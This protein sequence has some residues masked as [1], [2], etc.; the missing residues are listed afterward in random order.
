[1][2]V[3]FFVILKEY[4]CQIFSLDHVPQSEQLIRTYSKS[5]AETVMMY[6]RP[7]YVPDH[8]YYST[9]SVISDAIVRFN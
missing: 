2:N 7:V 1:L 8:L 3:P 9:S 4:L 5:A 6:A